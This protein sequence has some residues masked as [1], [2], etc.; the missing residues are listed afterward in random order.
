MKQ[1][2]IIFLLLVGTV[3]GFSQKILLLRLLIPANPG[4]PGSPA[5]QETQVL[6]VSTKEKCGL[7]VLLPV[8]LLSI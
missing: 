8:L 5:T 7:S 1:I 4:N 3:T 6:Q 2:L